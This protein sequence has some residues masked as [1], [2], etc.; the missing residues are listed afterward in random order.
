M[1]KLFC[2]LLS[3]LFL[4]GCTGRVAG[5]EIAEPEASATSNAGALKTGLG[6]IASTADSNDAD[7]QNN[8]VAQTNITLVAVTVDDS[9]VIHSCAIDDIQSKI[10]FDASGALV[11][12]PGAQ[13]L[14]KNGLGAEYGMGKASAIGQEWN[15]QAASMAA[16]ASG[17]TIEQLRG[18]SVD[19]NGRPTDADLAASVTISIGDFIS[20]IEAAVQNA[21][22]LGAQQG[23]QLRLVSLNSTSG[24]SVEPVNAK[25][26]AQLNASFAAATFRGDVISSCIIDALQSSVQFDSNGHIISDISAPVAT[27]NQLGRNYGMHEASSIGAEWNEQT[28]A[29]CNYVVGK[30]ISEINGISVDENGKPADADLAA[31]VTISI[32][33]FKKLLNRF[34]Q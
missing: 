1:K 19:A 11:S 4:S 5:V 9:G 24:N 8:G 26:N 33:D 13:V 17:K 6:V 14:S 31:T 32:G 2:I 12:E 34:A 22:P 7:A 15:Q 10:E 20:G 16:Y 21:A 25:G 28:A 18:I 30:T 29:F 23:D 27:K 3:L